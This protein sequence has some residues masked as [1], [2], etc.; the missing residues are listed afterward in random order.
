MFPSIHLFGILTFS[1]QSLLQAC[2]V[3]TALAVVER[4]ALRQRLRPDHLWTAAVLLGI[5]LFLGERLI[6]LLRSWH[7]FLAHP[8]WMLGLLSVHDPR[9]FDAGVAI[10]LAVGCLYLLA[11]RIA[12]SRAASV[13]TP[14]VLLLL[15]FV[16]AGYFAA[17]AQPGRITSHRW[18]LVSTNRFA[19]A[20]YGTPLH[21]PLIPVA[22]WACLGYTLIALFAEALAARGRN[23]FAAPIFAAGLLTVL[24]GQLELHW[25]SQLLIL[26][27]FTWT[28]ALAIAWTLLGAALLLRTSR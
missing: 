2:G 11:R 22:A 19:L 8:L 20:A 4:L 15:A 5:S 25:T 3:L 13:L 7:D 14:A 23:A 16:H 10:A 27:I 1:V 28:Q 24:L 18:G 17:G 9:L 6:L 12:L 26:G 21:V